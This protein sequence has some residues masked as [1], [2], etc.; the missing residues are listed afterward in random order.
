MNVCVH[1]LILCVLLFDFQDV[2][3]NK[4]AKRKYPRS[5]PN[6][7]DEISGG[8]FL[9]FWR[10]SK[11]RRSVKSVGDVRLETGDQTPQIKP[12][13]ECGDRVFT[14]F[15]KHADV[16]NLRI[17]GRKCKQNLLKLTDMNTS[18]STNYNFLFK[19]DGTYFVSS[20]NYLSL[21]ITLMYTIS[22]I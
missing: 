4:F 3:C 21:A 14:V 9:K 10:N 15:L 17:Y 8:F 22:P 7:H 12:Q 11:Q 19:I 6:G 18:M 5:G 2:L 16:I 20:H 1:L 13:Y